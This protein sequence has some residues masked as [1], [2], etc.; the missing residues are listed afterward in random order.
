MTVSSRLL[1]GAD[2]FCVAAA[3][4]IRNFYPPTMTS[5]ARQ[6]PSE[7]RYTR[8]QVRRPKCL[9]PSVPLY[10]TFASFCL[11]GCG[12]VRCSLRRTLVYPRKLT[13]ELDAIPGA[14][15]ALDCE[16]ARA[17]LQAAE[18]LVGR[19]DADVKVCTWERQKCPP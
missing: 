18:R 2:I 3:I 11:D 16:I 9:P 7:L 14:M 8:T 19:L 1:E 6:H 13:S 12:H 4:A 17:E 5:L 15:E 10:L